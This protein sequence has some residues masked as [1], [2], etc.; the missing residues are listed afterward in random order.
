[1][2]GGLRIL[3]RGAQSVAAHLL[4]LATLDKTL[5]PSSIARIGVPPTVN[6]TFHAAAKL[7]LSALGW[8]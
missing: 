7:K 4:D 6:L 8:K 5:K 1:M 3:K 2:L